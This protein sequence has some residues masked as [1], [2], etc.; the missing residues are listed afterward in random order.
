MAQR[1]VVAGSSGLIGGAL[2]RELLERGDTV[3]RLVRRQPDD[4]TS[5]RWDPATGFLP[6][7]VLDGVDAVVNLAGAGIGDRRW[8]PAR[9]QLIEQSRIEATSTLA[10]A[11]AA[12][13]VTSAGRPVRLVN[14][15]AVGYYGDRGDEVLT[16]TSAQ[17]TDFLAGLVGRWESATQPAVEAGAPVALLRT[18]LVMAPHGGAFEPLLRLARLGLG[19]PLGSGRQWWPWITVED[20][21]RAI[22]HLLDHPEIVGPVNL[23]A[24]GVARQREIAREIGRQLHRPAL[25]PAPTIALRVVIGEFAGAVVSSQR[26][27]PEVLLARGFEFRHPDLASAVRWMLAG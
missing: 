20:E 21:V 10:A 8:T 15:S 19:G 11:V 3:V 1:V 25:L 14:A 6:D 18:G 2:C 16:E 12:Q 27:A 22:L 4:P 26:M 13:G 7:G 23:A 17:G 9:K 24:P 5:V